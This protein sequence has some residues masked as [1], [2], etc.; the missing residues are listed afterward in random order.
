M[1]L[2]RCFILVFNIVLCS[3]SVY[4]QEKDANTQKGGSAT[5]EENSKKRPPAGFYD[6]RIVKPEQVSKRPL[7]A[8]AIV[9]PFGVV[10][11]QMEKGLNYVEESRAL[12]RLIVI[13]NHPNIRPVI[14]NLGD[15]SGFGGGAVLSTAESLSPF[16]IFGLGHITSKRYLQGLAGV[17]VRPS[18]A[19]GE[20]LELF[21]TAELRLR[22]EEDFWGL[23]AQSDTTR[24]NY[25]L[26]N[27]TVS[28]GLTYRPTTN[29]R[30]GTTLVY[31]SAS[32]FAGRDKRFPTTQSVFPVDT[33]PGL[34]EGAALLSPTAFVE[35]DARGGR[36]SPIRGFYTMAT[37]ASNDS[38]G[39]GDYGFWSYTVD[40]RLY[41]PLLSDGRVL[42][43]RTLLWFNDPKGGSQ[44]PFFRMAQLGDSQ[45]LRGY[46]SQ[47]FRANNAA[48]WNVEYR[49]DLTGF[50]GA[51][52]FTDFGQVF[53]SRSEFNTENFRV[54]YGG[55]LQFKTRESIF[56][57][58]Y[59]AKSDESSRFFFTVGPTF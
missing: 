33:V 20:K 18:P 54:T 51:F 31:D 46:D 42:A 34:A 56:L 5:E 8:R 22:P 30:A 48:A 13:L 9:A 58:V 6:D 37:V 16:K 25:D 24:T 41:I 28:A 45:T 57:R 19:L 36:S 3:A 49:T 35:Y 53:N 40:S 2:F 59:L 1:T 27:R 32:V 15:G 44:V 14:G 39:S 26:Q 7:I 11:R 43:A 21:T 55:G 12:D 23:G 50:I 29:W 4:A 52:A 47:R 17:S 38:V 10:G